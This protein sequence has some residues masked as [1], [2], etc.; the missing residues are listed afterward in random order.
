M[1]VCGVSPL[2]AW[3]Q[4][5]MAS[6]VKV[7]ACPEI[8]S[9]PVRKSTMTATKQSINQSINE[10]IEQVGNLVTNQA[11]IKSFSRLP[12]CTSRKLLRIAPASRG[13]LLLHLLHRR[14]RTGL[15]QCLRSLALWTLSFSSKPPKNQQFS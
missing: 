4:R 6:R 1:E 8:H 12:A 2:S 14:L 13:T 10:S 9:Q 15:T 5:V 3:Y 11:R 7:V